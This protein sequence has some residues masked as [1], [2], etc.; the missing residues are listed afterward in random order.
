MR[1]LCL[2]Y[3][4]EARVN[5]MSQQEIDALIDETT[6]NNEELR[7]S[8]QLI[9]AQALEQVDEAMTV[10][11]RDGRLSVTDGP[12]AETNEQLGGF[13]LIEARDLNEALQIAGRIPSARLGSVEVRPVIDLTRERGS[14]AST[15]RSRA[16]SWPP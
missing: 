10:R 3:A 14:T 4:D 15:A 12:F 5:G 1:Y 16:R 6:A 2:V 8:R 11:V 7:A 9:L 13:V